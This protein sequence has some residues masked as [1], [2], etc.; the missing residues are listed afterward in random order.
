MGPE[1]HLITIFS[2]MVSINF[3]KVFS[4]TPI[5]SSRLVVY[6][7]VEVNQAI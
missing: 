2:V 7:L 5:N 3:I 6:P 4:L 1:S